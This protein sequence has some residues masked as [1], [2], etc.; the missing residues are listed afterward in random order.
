MP[1]ILIALCLWTFATTSLTAGESP[2]AADADRLRGDVTRLLGELDSDR[3]EVR[4]DAA[5][6]LEE[7][8]AKPEL[9][10]FLAGEFQ[11]VLVRPDVSFE[12]RWHL[13]R[14]TKRLPAPEPG[15][16]GD[17]SPEELDQLV[18]Q[19]DDDSYAVRLGAA[20][21]VEWLS[22][23]PKLVCPLLIRLETP[24][25]R[26]RAGRRGSTTT[27]GRLAAGARTVAVE[28]GLSRARVATTGLSP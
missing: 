17:A 8:V 22:N 21:R 11:Q 3:F 27:G 28:R 26:C 14:W 25:G 9:G 6:R 19:L 16:V 23:N 1:R 7:L 18:R 12:V 15:L 10:R 5:E 13:T 2:T 20:Q 4:R 24:P